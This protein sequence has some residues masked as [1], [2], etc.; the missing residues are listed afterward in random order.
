MPHIDNKSFPIWIIGY[1]NQQRRDDGIGPYIIARL[2]Q[3]LRGKQGIR[4][5]AVHQLGPELLPELRD[6][7]LIIFVDAAMNEFK[8]GWQWAR[9]EPE[10]GNLPCL[11]HHFHPGFL[12]GLLQSLYDKSPEAWMIS[13][14]GDNF[15]IGEGLTEEVENRA[16]GVVAEIIS[17]V[18]VNRL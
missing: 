6:A 1:G 13:V 5:L 7:A 2:D 4:T 12:L 14:Q 8:G 15:D 3:I 16:S 11:S 18:R 17:F 10:H 9:V